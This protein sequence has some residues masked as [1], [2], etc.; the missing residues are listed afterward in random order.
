M[1]IYIYI[2]LY[3]YCII[4][5]LMYYYCIFIVLL[6]YYPL[7]NPIASHDIS[8]YPIFHLFR[9][10]ISSRL[11]NGRRHLRVVR[12]VSQDAAAG[13]HRGGSKGGREAEDRCQ[14]AVG[15]E[16]PRTKDV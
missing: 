5:L 10:A 6:L 14:I 8:S 13:D 9:L 2:L 3:Y 1:Y 15:V 12:D 7:T 16:V 11:P 4:V